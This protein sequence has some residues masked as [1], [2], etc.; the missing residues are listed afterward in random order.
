MS[1]LEKKST[2]EHIEKKINFK[3]LVSVMSR[4]FTNGLNSDLIMV[5]Q[6][7]GGEG[8]TFRLKIM[9]P[10]HTFEREI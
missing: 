2:L 8:V 9:L 5:W 4:F 3:I 1:M 6:G 10:L 7:R